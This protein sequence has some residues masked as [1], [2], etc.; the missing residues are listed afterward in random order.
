MSCA[1]PLV[2][3]FDVPASVPFVSSLCTL[4][5]WSSFLSLWPWEHPL[6]RYPRLWLPVAS[7]M[8]AKRR[9]R[10]QVEILSSTQVRAKAPRDGWPPVRLMRTVVS[11]ERRLLSHLQSSCSPTRYLPRTHPQSSSKPCIPSNS[12]DRPTTPSIL[13]GVGRSFIP[14][15]K[16]YGSGVLQG[17]KA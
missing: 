14:V 9:T 15:P 1:G 7:P 17:S 2:P 13:R 8:Q 11:T 10:R 16:A 6:A 3:S 4:V 12:S 5:S